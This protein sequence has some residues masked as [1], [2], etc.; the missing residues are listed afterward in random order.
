MYKKVMIVMIAIASL[1]IL[2]FPVLGLPILEAGAAQL[3]DGKTYFVHLPTFLEVE[4]T[5]NYIYA[6]NATYYFKVALPLNMGENLQRLEI[7]Q[8][9]GFETID[10]WLDQTIAYVQTT[11]GDRLPITGKAEIIQNQDRDQ[12]KVVITFEPPIPAS[13]Q[14][15][16]QLVVGLRPFRNPRYGGVYLFGVSASPQGDRPHPQFLGYGRLNFYD[17]F[18]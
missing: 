7:L 16:R 8:S 14:P 2:S 3:R 12:R 10:F 6:R 11:S 1:P 4:T 5:E 13:G 9:E 15:N 18:R 17:P